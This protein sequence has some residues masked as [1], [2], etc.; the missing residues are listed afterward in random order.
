[1]Q[2]GIGF[3]GHRPVPAGWQEALDEFNDTSNLA[4]MVIRWEP[5]DPWAPVQRWNIWQMLPVHL[6]PDHI[7]REFLEGASPRDFARWDS[8]LG[9]MVQHRRGRPPISLAQWRMFREH[10]HRYIPLRFWTLQGHP[11]EGGHKVV[12]SRVDKMVSRMY[13]GAGEPPLNGSLPYLELTETTM[14][15]LRQE[16]RIRRHSFALDH[17]LKNSE[18]Y[19]RREEEV[20]EHMKEQIWKQLGEKVNTTLDLLTREQLLASAGLDAPIRSFGGI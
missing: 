11:E 16:D 8:K 4:R 15:K 6:F 19:D 9:R 13:G 5:G 12:Y 18:Q 20:I 2:L 14:R 10:D 3:E 17:Y 7:I 1:M